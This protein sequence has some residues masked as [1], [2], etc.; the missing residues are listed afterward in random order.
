[1]LSEVSKLDL[2]RYLKPT[3]ESAAAIFWADISLNIE[4]Q[5]KEKRSELAICIELTSISLL[6]S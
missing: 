1:V 4:C 2:H 5:D 6:P 3:K